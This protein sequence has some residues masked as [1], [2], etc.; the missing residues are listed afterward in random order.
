MAQFR[1]NF[2]PNDRVWYFDAAISSYKEGTVYQTEIKVFKEADL[3]VDD[4]L[5]YLVAVDGNPNP[6]RVS[7]SQLFMDSGLGIVAPPLSPIYTVLYDYAP[8]TNVWVVNRAQTSVRY[9]NVYQAEL[10]I[11]AKINLTS[12]TKITYYVSY[13]DASG[14]T[15]ASQEDVFATSTEAWASLGIVIGPAPTPVPTGTPVP[16]GSNIIT[17]SKV[18][19]DSVTL[20]KGMPVYIKNDG[21]IARSDNDSKAL[22]FLGFVYDDSIPVDGQGQVMT[23]GVLENTLQNWDNVVL[24]APTLNASIPYYLNGLGTISENPPSNGYSREVGLG[25]SATEFDIRIMSPYGI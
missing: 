5:V 8:N 25:V 4:T 11:F 9:G 6:L 12:E 24:G 3:S 2:H 16:G 10:K 18:N 14:T 19:S 13:S 1:Y 20:Y 22:T 23:E 21:T 17:V 15:R 7:E